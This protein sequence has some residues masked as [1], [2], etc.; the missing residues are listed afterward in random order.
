MFELI[1][2]FIIGTVWYKYE[3]RNK[4]YLG[5]DWLELKEMLLKEAKEQDKNREEKERKLG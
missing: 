3:G 1:I 2:G 4:D 5:K